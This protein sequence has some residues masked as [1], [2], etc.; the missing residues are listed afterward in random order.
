MQPV[1]WPERKCRETVWKGDTAHSCEVIDLHPGPCASTSSQES[2][3]RRDA[4]EKNNPGWK[5][6]MD[7][8]PFVD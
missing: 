8:D 4:W 6:S 5:R 7:K 3:D 2:V 1:E